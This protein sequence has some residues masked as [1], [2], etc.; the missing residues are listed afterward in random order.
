MLIGVLKTTICAAWMMVFGSVLAAAPAEWIWGDGDRHGEGPARFGT[1]FELDKLPSGSAELRVIGDFCSYQVMLNGKPVA[2][3]GAYDDLV[4]VPVK[5]MLTTGRNAIEVRAQGVAGPSALA[6][7]LALVA[8]DG[9]RR[10]VL[11][12]SGAWDGANSIAP[13]GILGFEGARFSDV[14]AFAEY[15]QWKEAK[16]GEDGAQGSLG[17]V[18]REGLQV[19]RVVSA[20]VEPDHDVV[21]AVDRGVDTAVAAAADRLDQPIGTLRHQLVAQPTVGFLVLCPLLPQIDDRGVVATD[22]V[23][24]T[25]LQTTGQQEHEERHDHNRS[26]KANDQTRH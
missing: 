18:E 16:R 11:R 21:L 15:N 25:T 5:V 8:P 2:R 3:A 4:I 7:D 12:S 14:D 17:V 10:Q 9:E 24:V 13:L 22:L 19:A 26:D 6:L 20:D 23:G 1:S